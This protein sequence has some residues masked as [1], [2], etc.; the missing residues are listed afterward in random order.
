MFFPA[1][2]TLLASEL[3]IKI[4]QLLGEKEV[5]IDKSWQITVHSYKDK[6]YITNIKEIDNGSK[7]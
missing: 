6:K 5:F 2:N 1:L 4:V 7:N 3:Q